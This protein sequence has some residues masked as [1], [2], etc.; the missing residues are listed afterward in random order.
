MNT[1]PEA[2]R[3]ADAIDLG[4]ARSAIDCIDAAAELRRLHEV[5]KQLLSAL[6][7]ADAL[8]TQLIMPNIKDI[9]LQ[10]YGFLNNTLLNNRAAIAKAQGEIK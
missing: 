7:D 8:I 1:Q 4:K 5:N 10:D 2:L 6:K 3:L 9:V